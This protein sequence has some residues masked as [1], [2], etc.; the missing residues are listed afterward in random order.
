MPRSQL[1]SARAESGFTLVELLVAM[2]ASMIVLIGLSEVLVAV[3]HQSQAT[4]TRVA[5]T[6]NA[7]IGFSTIENELHSACVSSGAA[8][9]FAPIQSGSTATSMSFVTYT[10]PSLNPTPTWHVLTLTS[11]NTLTDTTET[12]TGSAGNW[13]PVA[14]SAQTTTLL[15]NVTAYTDPTTKTTTPVFQYFYYADNKAPDGGYWWVIPDGLSAYPNGTVP[16]ASPITPLPLTS[17]TAGQTVEVLVTLNVGATPDGAA[18][19]PAS[20]TT[21]AQTDSINLRLTTPPDE[22]PAGTTPANAQSNYGPC[23]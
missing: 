12:V 5:S 11:S 7:R 4:V 8:N 21:D 18:P 22:T 10:G 17:T 15:S 13:S 14:S 23:E 1:T 3:L 19:S 6:R 20:G 9:G 16:T 2:A